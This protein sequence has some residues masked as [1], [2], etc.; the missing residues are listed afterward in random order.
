MAETELDLT[1]E[2]RSL[3]QEIARRTGR[4]ESELIHEAI[5]RLIDGFAAE[6][7]LSLF[8][9][10][11]GIWKDRSDLPVFEELRQEWDRFQT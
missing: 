9:Q 2:E 8:R 11:K 1:E 6:N 5:S 10:A 3:L 7:R 4:S